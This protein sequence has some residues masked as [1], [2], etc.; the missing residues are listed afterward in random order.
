MWFRPFVNQQRHTSKG[1]SLVEVMITVAVMAI[2]IG[3][4]APSLST[5][6]KNNRMTEVSNKLVSAIIL[7]RNEAVTRRATVTVTGNDA[8]WTVGV[9]PLSTTT[10]TPLTSYSLENDVRLVISNNSINSITFKP[11]GFRD[12][13]GNTSSFFFTVC[14][15]DTTDT[16]IVNVSAAGTTSVTKGTGGCP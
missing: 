10:I 6:M 11:D 2:A 16:R 1:Y 9:I 13:S 15:A 4:A 12:A 5:F 14:S 8:G 3:L 7:A